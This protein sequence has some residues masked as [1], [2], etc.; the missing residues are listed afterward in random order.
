MLFTESTLLFTAKPIVG[1]RRKH[2]KKKIWF[3]ITIADPGHRLYNLGKKFESAYQV[4]VT[5]AFIFEGAWLKFSPLIIGHNLGNLK[6][7]ISITAASSFFWW[8]FTFHTT[9]FKRWAWKVNFLYKRNTY[10]MHKNHLITGHFNFIQRENSRR[11][12]RDKCQFFF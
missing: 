7:G 2:K 10:N 9:L 3:W 4:G 5:A 6:A 11:R 8:I 12:L 1:K